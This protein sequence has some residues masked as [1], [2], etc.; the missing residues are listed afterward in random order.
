MMKF[1]QSWTWR[2]LALSLAILAASLSGCSEQPGTSGPATSEGG[3]AAAAGPQSGIVPPILLTGRGTLTGDAHD[4]G[5]PFG[6]DRRAHFHPH[7]EQVCKSG[8]ALSSHPTA[9]LSSKKF[10]E[11]MTAFAGEPMSEDSPAL[12]ALLYFGRQTADWIERK[13][14]A[15]LD[16]KR[17]EFLSR[18]LTRTHA[19]VSFR[20][21]DDRGVRRVWLPPTRVPFDRRHEF[22]MEVEDLPPLHISG[23]VKRV[24]LH[25][26]WVRL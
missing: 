5:D 19:L 24:G 7:G 1:W 16:S 21:V 20:I 2:P 22:R 3:Q 14:A 25:H 26:I 12:E 13:G 23:T 17:A 18:E 6:H 9:D 11:L 15:P 8:C 10:R 4:P